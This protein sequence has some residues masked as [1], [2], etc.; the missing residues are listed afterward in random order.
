MFNVCCT[1][2]VN[3][4]YL[5]LGRYLYHPKV[6]HFR[7]ESNVPDYYQMGPG[8]LKIP[9]SV[10]AANREKVSRNWMIIIITSQSQLVVIYYIGLQDRNIYNIIRLPHAY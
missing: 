6:D 2:I 10:F 1:C 7:N 8:T 4:H 5:L 3:F 9:N